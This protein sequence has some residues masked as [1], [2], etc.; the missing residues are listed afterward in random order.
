MRDDLSNDI[1]ITSE[2]RDPLKSARK[3]ARPPLPKRWSAAPSVS[4]K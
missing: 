4:L 1:F 3:D 2:E